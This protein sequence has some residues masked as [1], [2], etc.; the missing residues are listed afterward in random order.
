MAGAELRS[1]QK[2]NKVK[3]KQIRLSDARRACAKTFLTAAPEAAEAVCKL[4]TKE[5]KE[6]ALKY[7]LGAIGI[8]D[9]VEQTVASEAENEQQDAFVS[10]AFERRLIEDL[11]RA[12]RPEGDEDEG[13]TQD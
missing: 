4:A 1:R 11:R 9:A 6:W 10:T 7:V 8:E 3:D 2:T 12:G 5:K 13:S